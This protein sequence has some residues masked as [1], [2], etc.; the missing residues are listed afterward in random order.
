MTLRELSRAQRRLMDEFARDPDA[1]NDELAY[2]LGW[3]V[4]YVEQLF[5]GVFAT[6]R[7]TT[8]AGA[9]V[10]HIRR[11]GS[12]VRRQDDLTEPMGL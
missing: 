12:R 1:R 5:A 11:R 6:Y 2:R 4:G 8:R 3:S 9:V 7:V 10:A